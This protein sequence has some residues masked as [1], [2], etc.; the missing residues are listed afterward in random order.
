MAVLPVISLDRR[1]QGY[2]MVTYGNSTYIYLSCTINHCCNVMDVTMDEIRDGVSYCCQVS[3]V[4]PQ[5]AV[6]LVS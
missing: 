6:D 3:T 5:P 1:F 4:E 2:P